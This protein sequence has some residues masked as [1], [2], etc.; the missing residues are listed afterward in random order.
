MIVCR[1]QVSSHCMRC[2]LLSLYQRATLYFLLALSLFFVAE[3]QSHHHQRQRKSQRQVTLSFN[4][5]LHPQLA[6]WPA[7]SAL[8]PKPP[9]H[10]RER[11][12]SSPKKSS[13][14]CLKIQISA[15]RSSWP[16]KTQKFLPNTRR[17][18][19]SNSIF[20]RT[21]LPRRTL[22]WK[23]S[24]ASKPNWKTTL[25]PSNL[26]C[27]Q[28]C[29]KCATS[30]QLGLHLLQLDPLHQASQFDLHPPLC[31]SIEMPALT[32][33]LLELKPMHPRQSFSI[34]STNGLQRHPTS[35]PVTMILKALPLAGTSSYNSMAV[36]PILIQGPKEQLWQISHSGMKTALGGN[37]IPPVPKTSNWPCSSQKTH[38]PNISENLHLQN[39]FQRR[40]RG[41]SGKTMELP[42][43]DPL[44]LSNMK[45]VSW[46][47]WNANRLRN[48]RSNGCS[49]PLLLPRST[50]RKC[51]K[52]STPMLASHQI[53]LGAVSKI[54]H[55]GTVSTQK[56]LSIVSWNSRGLFAQDP[57]IRSKKLAALQKTSFNADIIL[58]QE[59]HPDRYLINKFLLIF[60]SRFHIWW[61]MCPKASSGGLITMARKD[62][63]DA[64]ATLTYT[65]NI[66]PGRISSLTI[67]LNGHSSTYWNIHNYGITHAQFKRARLHLQQDISQAALNPQFFSVWCIGDFNREPA[68]FPRTS[69]KDPTHQ[70]FPQSG[71]NCTANHGSAWDDIF[72]QMIEV[73]SA[74]PTHYCGAGMFLNKLDRFFITI[75]SH[76]WLTVKPSI[77]VLIRPEFANAEGISDHGILKLGVSLQA[78]PDPDTMPIRAEVFKHPLFEEK[79]CDL[80]EYIDLDS[81]SP[82]DRWTTHKRLLREATSQVRTEM[83]LQEEDSD[84]S[85]Q[86]TH[87]SLSRAI[88]RNDIRLATKIVD[89]SSFARPQRFH[90]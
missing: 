63:I 84:F 47:R 8:A 59:A 15:C 28:K 33:C 16:M 25:E 81:L 52:T 41:I 1:T 66:V 30:F 61:T 48:S 82:W 11:R 44:E 62:K 50:R 75:P 27:K 34:L 49:M 4:I 5:P 71:H 90:F 88:W 9:S 17:Q 26:I 76:A 43:I 87:S 65:G 72:S 55:P 69:V 10:P 45:A 24:K 57:T 21:Q 68:D 77:Q 36:P 60:A 2:T 22:K 73:Y 86:A 54:L 78:P 23:Q 7:G 18:S 89:R 79:I 32:S 58:I 14:P 42:F 85:V 80:Y 51:L 19:S 37:C 56:A 20:S 31:T 70:I 6:P 53:V 35:L 67:L 38:L 64:D 29:K 83:L 3:C 12:A 13:C 74:Q 40:L 46:Q 39:D